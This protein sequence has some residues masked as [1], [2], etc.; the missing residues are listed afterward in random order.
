MTTTQPGLRT[1]MGRIGLLVFIFNL[2]W[3]TTN[4]AASSFLQAA[5]G[6]VVPGD[7][8]NFYTT[9]ST[10]GALL[11]AVSIIVCGALSDNT[12]SRLGKRAPWILGGGALA[13]V[14]LFVT[15]ATHVPA[16]VILGWVG[17][18]MGL[19]G[20]IAAMLAVPADLLAPSV[21]G[22]FS[23]LA[24]LGVLL[25][26]VG[27][28]VLTAVLITKP[29]QGLMLVPW[30]LLLGA[31][32]AAVWLP[33]RSSKD[34]PVAVTS[35]RDFF[36]ALVPTSDGRY[37]WVFAG[38]F[39]FILALY[40]IVLYQYFIATDHIGLDQQG[41]GNLIGTASIILALCA[42]LATL[43]AGP[44]S[45]RF[46]RKPFVLG[47]PL[48][49]IVGI[50]PLLAAPSSATFLVFYV[51][52]GSAYGAYLSV[53]AALMMDVLP[54][55]ENMAKDLS[56]LNAANTLPAVFAPMIA[57]TLTTVLGF[58]ASFVAVMVACA[59]S[60]VCILRVKGVR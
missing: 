54:D 37:W 51:L 21:Y 48:L 28:G 29:Q 19:N 27:G 59:A 4:N 43:V 17:Y 39:L 20:M 55:G 10:V 15:G 26:S 44:L 58:S 47:A 35:V 5:S 18:Q 60:A 30:I 23:G 42:G 12:R 13:T 25:G 41:A 9:V 6:A 32:I 36:R 57:G 1:T 16:L 33:R 53:D 45:D 49:A 40:M 34:E 31:I 7:A 52:G 14:S 8:V 50:V 38:R 46:G 24:G 3:S 11:A 2:A 56:I 22:R